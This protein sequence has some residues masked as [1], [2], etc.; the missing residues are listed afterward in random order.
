MTEVGLSQKLSTNFE[1]YHLLLSSCAEVDV[2]TWI[3]FNEQCLSGVFLTAADPIQSYPYPYQILSL[4]LSNPIPVPIQSSTLSAHLPFGRLL[5]LSFSC[6]TVLSSEYYWIF[7]W[8]LFFKLYFSEFYSNPQSL[9]YEIDT[10]AIAKASD[11]CLW[12]RNLLWMRQKLRDYLA[13]LTKER[14]ETG[15][16]A[17]NTSQTS[18]RPVERYPGPLRRAVT[19]H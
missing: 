16:L 15:K 4:S 18:S 17:L 11:F 19:S 6:R 3:S 8:T 10:H 1:F 7:Y 5:C 13:L 14:E 9:I 12:T 2:T